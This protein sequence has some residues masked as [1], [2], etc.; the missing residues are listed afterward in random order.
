[1]KFNKKDD[2]FALIWAKRIRGIRLLGGKCENCGS[3]NVLCLDFHHTKDKEFT[4]G[5]FKTLRW[6]LLEKEIKKCNLLCKNCHVELHCNSN[7]RRHGQKRKLIESV[8]K[9]NCEKCGYVGKNYSSLEFHHFRDKKFN[10]A[11]GLYSSHKVVVSVQ[12][13]MDEIEKCKILCRNCHIQEH[14]NVNKFN[15]L[16]NIIMQKVETYKELQ[17]PLDRQTIYNMYDNGKGVCQIAKELNCWKSTISMILTKYKN[18]V[19]SERLKEAPR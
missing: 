16:N 11:D 8:G 17:K 18:G 9:L 3:S 1:M 4:I 7:G 12:E 10:I 19:V 13:L 6:S 5:A 14:I 15:E 2:T